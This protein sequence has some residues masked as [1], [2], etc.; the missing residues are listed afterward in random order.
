ML[1]TEIGMS[2]K[3]HGSNIKRLHHI[4]LFYIIMNKIKQQIIENEENLFVSEKC[5]GVFSDIKTCKNQKK[6]CM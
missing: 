3:C 6:K 4:S 1:D 2:L 5:P